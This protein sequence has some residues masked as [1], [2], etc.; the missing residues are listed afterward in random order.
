MLLVTLIFLKKF[1]PLILSGETHIFNIHSISAKTFF[2]NTIAYSA[3]EYAKKAM[4]GVLE[5]E[6][7]KYDIRFS[8]F[9]V[10]AIDTPLWESYSESEKEKML[11]TADFI[12]MFNSVL[13]A[14]KSI[15]FPELTF[16]HRDGYID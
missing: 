12:Y 8:H 5:K 16:L 2:P 11:S 14:P 10:G 15:Q 6:W 3:G 13:D 4:L 9:Y 1:E 7:K